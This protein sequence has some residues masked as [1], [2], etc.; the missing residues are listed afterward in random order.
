MTDSCSDQGAPG[1][2][3]VGRA[4][5]YYKKDFWIAENLK[6][7]KPWY[8]LE[9]SARIIRRL[10]DGAECE[11]LDIGCGPAALRRLLP[12]NVHY[13]GLDIAIQ[14]PAP[15]LI[16]LDITENP[17]EFKGKSFDIVIAQGLFEYLG[18]FQSE[19]F[20]EISDLLNDDGKFITS[21]TNFGHR[22][23]QAYWLSNNVR[24]IDNFK[25]DLRRHFN[26]DQ[27]FPASHNWKHAQPNR[28]L[29]KTVN[30][31]MNAN[32]PFISPKL[33]VEY[34]FVCSRPA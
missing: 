7:S 5:R 20:A 26:I 16:E 25:N 6:F 33:A 1:S 13:H 14:Q 11:L 12:S 9:K 23:Y 28:A 31:R 17:I 8:R 18:E 2:D 32:V 29:V 3:G 24:S 27:V 21:Y 15:C 4:A 34:F 19:K 30:L 10:A 22:R